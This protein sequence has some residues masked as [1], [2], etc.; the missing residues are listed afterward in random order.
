[1]AD[2]RLLKGVP[3]GQVAGQPVDVADDDHVDLARLDRRDQLPE[4][5]TG[6]FLE[7]R[8]PVI[9]EGG[10]DLPVAPLCVVGAPVKLGRHRLG[11]VVGLAQTAIHTRPELGFRQ[12]FLGCRPCVKHDAKHS[13]RMASWSASWYRCSRVRSLS[14]RPGADSASSTLAHH[15]G[16]FRVWSPLRTLRPGTSS[17]AA[18]RGQRTRG[19]GPRPAGPRG[20]ARTSPRTAPKGPPAPGP[21]PRP[22][23]A[24]HRTHPGTSPAAGPSTGRSPGRRTTTGPGGQRGD[25]PG[26]R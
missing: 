26:R 3:V 13:G 18:P 23:P 19:P 11:R 22:S 14:S 16:H 10:D 4:P 17:P 8:V 20:P 1:V 2:A 9:L 12:K 24:A 7:R 6:D 15:S 5:V 25:D 21:R